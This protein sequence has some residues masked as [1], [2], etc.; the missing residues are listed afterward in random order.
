MFLPLCFNPFMRENAFKC[1]N[2]F[3]SFIQNAKMQSD[4]FKK[5][6]KNLQSCVRALEQLGLSFRR[7]HVI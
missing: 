1:A 6:K 7:K 3:Y 4:F 5:G 2:K